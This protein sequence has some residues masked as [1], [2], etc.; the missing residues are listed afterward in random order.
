MGT[1]DGKEEEVKGKREIGGKGEKGDSGGR[2]K[3]EE[4]E[5]GDGFFQLGAGAIATCKPCSRRVKFY[6]KRFSGLCFDP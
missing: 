6:F 2:G 5:M 4:M 3:D 1:G